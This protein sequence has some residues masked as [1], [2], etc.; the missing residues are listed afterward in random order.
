MFGILICGLGSEMVSAE[1]DQDSMVKTIMISTDKLS[2]QPEEPIIV[3][4]E[5][6]ERKMPIIALRIFDPDGKILG[7]YGVE[8]DENNQ[9][10]K[11]IM[12]YV[13][14]YEKPGIYQITA[15]YGKLNSETIFEIE[16]D[17]FEIEYDIPIIEEHTELSPQILSFESDKEIYQDGDTIT[18]SGEVSSFTESPVTIIIFDP[19]GLLSGI[20]LA[21]INP[22]LTFS[23]SFLAKYEVNF[24][25]EGT[26]LITAQYGGLETKRS[27]AIEFV[28]NTHQPMVIDETT[29]HTFLFSE[30]DLEQLAT[31]YYLDGSNNELA[32]FFNDLL[33]RDLINPNSDVA[34]S[35]GLLVEWI[36][37]NKTSLGFMIEDL[38]E[39]NISEETF[40]LFIED[41]LN[42]YT[43]VSK[44]IPQHIVSSNIITHQKKIVN[45]EK[46]KTVKP[47]VLDL[48]NKIETDYTNYRLDKKDEKV[49]FYS[50][51]DCE[52]GTYEDVISHYNSPGPAFAHL[53][54]YNDAI[55]HYDKT[56][57]LNPNNIHALTNKGSALAS[58]GNYQE[59]ISYYDK[60]LEINLQ[61][62][63]ALN[64]KG[65]ALAS[66]GNY[67]EAISYYDKALEINPQYVI[68][69]NNKEKASVSSTLL[70]VSEE[71][72]QNTLISAEEIPLPKEQEAKPNDIVTQFVGVLSS[73]GAS[74]VTWFSG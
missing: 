42:D 36:E 65:N 13:P 41:S 2:Y 7:A 63:I 8:L 15:E 55:Y 18:I 25:V 45:Q 37:D 26:Y 35:R 27:L 64:N 48:S 74:L 29:S 23:T 58:L 3:S 73:I 20:Y 70:P 67:Q 21:D 71:E 38:F 51:V 19:S 30:P 62:V 12:A 40:I 57:E 17:L 61:Y 66:L 6:T 44:H 5:V 28:E 52:K 31:W 47:D 1:E 56:L 72:S 11:T 4:G 24:K 53:C 68:A 34:I 16:N 32:S 50:S 49:Y 14:F 22:D 60:A 43:K 59:A 69:L 54:K 9:F 46:S 33:K 39:G 10:S